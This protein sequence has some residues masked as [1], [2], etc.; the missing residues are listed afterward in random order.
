MSDQKQVN[1]RIPK[2]KKE[3]W[4]EFAEENYGSMTRLVTTAVEKEISGGTSAAET[5]A[6]A[7]PDSEAVTDLQET[8][9][10]LQGDMNDVQSQLTGVREAVQSGPGIS[11]RAAVRETLPELDAQFAFQEE[12]GL[13]A[14]QVAA[15]LD[16][17]DDEIQDALDTLEAQ[18]PAVES[19]DVD[20]TAHYYKE[21]E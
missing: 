21:A 1:I 17:D 4:D 18:H 11:V 14:E 6:D 13:T 8:V 19:A 9:N 3:V 20:G 16:G 12:E 15:R 5:S 10:S 7:A 2:S